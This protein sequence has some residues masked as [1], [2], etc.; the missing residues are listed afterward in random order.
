MAR[1]LDAL[2]PHLAAFQGVDLQFAVTAL[3][4]LHHQPPPPFVEAFEART[5]ALLAADQV[6]PRDLA[7]IIWS[8]A[9]L[10]VKSP[11]FLRRLMSAA[12]AQLEAERPRWGQQQQGQQRGGGGEGGATTTTVSMSMQERW[13]LT[14]RVR[15][16]RQVHLYAQCHAGRE[17]DELAGLAQEF[18]DMGLLPLIEEVS[19]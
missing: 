3:V 17:G 18:E 10:D 8:F 14:A 2:A 13:C 6:S 4:G 1:L 11:A 5:L 12:V 16:L 7:I 9:A 19:C 15:Q